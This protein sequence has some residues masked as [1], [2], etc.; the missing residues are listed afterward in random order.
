[1]IKCSIDLNFKNSLHSDYDITLKKYDA[2]YFKNICSIYDKGRRSCMYKPSMKVAEDRSRRFQR[3]RKQNV[4]KMPQFYYAEMRYYL[5]T[6]D[7]I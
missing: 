3:W 5:S 4:F 2:E 7:L 6:N 1:M